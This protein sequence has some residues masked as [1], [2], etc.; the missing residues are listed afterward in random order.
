MGVRILL[1]TVY[2]STLCNVCF[3]YGTVDRERINL[4]AKLAAAVS[5][6]KIAKFANNRGESSLTS[7]MI[8][9]EREKMKTLFAIFAKTF[10]NFANW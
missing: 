1:R 2:R 7:P 6:A 9:G 4:L 10:G 5:F 8:H 3:W